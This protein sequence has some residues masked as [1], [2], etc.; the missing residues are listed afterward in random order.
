MSVNNLMEIDKNYV[1]AIDKFLTKFNET[2]PKLPSEEEE[3]IKHA[4]I[5]KLRDNPETT[6]ENEL[7]EKLSIDIKTKSL[8]ENL[9]FISLMSNEYNI[10]KKNIIKN[11]LNYIIRNRKSIVT[12]DF[13]CFVENIMHIPDLNIDYMIPLAILK[14]NTFFNN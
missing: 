1:S 3:I 10:D 2:Q 7:W 12:N 14:L 5:F 6:K 9:K 11:Y 13:L 8:N 4:R